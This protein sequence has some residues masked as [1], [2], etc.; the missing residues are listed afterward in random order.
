MIPPIQVDPP[1]YEAAS[2]LMG[3]QAA[4]AVESALASLIGTLSG[5]GSMAGN[6]QAGSAWSD[7]Y[8][9]A[10]K[11]I[12]GAMSSVGSGML[13]VGGLLQR[14]GFNHGIAESSSD[15]TRSVAAPV[16]SLSYASSGP[17]GYTGQVASVPAA[18]GGSGS[19]PSGWELVEHAVGWVWPDGDPD[20]LRTAAT[21]WTTAGNDL[22][23]VQ[24]WVGRTLT[25]I[26]EQ[27]SPEVSAATTVCSQFTGQLTS[28]T[29][30]CDQMASACTGLATH[31]ETAHSNVESEL[32]SFLEWTAGIEGVGLLGSVFTLGGAEVAAQ[33]AEATELGNVV[34]R[35]LVF[36]KDLLE[37]AKAVIAFIRDALPGVSE[38]DTAA[39][40]LA[41]AAPELADTST[42]RGIDEVSQ[43]GK[44]ATSAGDVNPSV[45]GEPGAVATPED[46]A[47]GDLE[48][49][50]SA[51]PEQQAKYDKYVKDKEAKGLAPRSIKGWW[52]KVS[53][54]ARN[55]LIGD[56]ERDAVYDEM[57]LTKT[58]G[59]EKELGPG[60]GNPGLKGLRRR[61]DIVN[62]KDA[63]AIEVKSGSSPLKETLAQLNKDARAL[64]AGW[65]ITWV[66]KEDLSPG[67][68]ERILELEKQY[69]RFHY[70]M[71]P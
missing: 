66:L 46:T 8:D 3:T 42:V 32:T 25:A 63:E 1:V 37:G 6:D 13:A 47:L 19:A 22:S 26:C 38:A 30:A 58:D 71:R 54:L 18:A 64:R 53:T 70:E 31:I 61:W 59:W 2:A 17:N 52:N 34:A 5:C 9:P 62:Q 51:S 69:P 20:R 28:L 41:D 10:A 27:H 39:A 49:Y 40:K 35:I 7:E 50:E 4:G 55:K 21:A 33:I 16:D 56:A 11:Q 45:S 23:N 48:D 60:K 65:K 14:T 57:G 44:L 12:V 29:S 36:L 68:M 24:V 67:L 15:P 43:D